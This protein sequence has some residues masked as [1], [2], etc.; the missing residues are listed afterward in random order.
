MS[1][2]PSLISVTCSCDAFMNRDCD[3]AISLFE[4]SLRL[5]GG[6]D[7]FLR[8]VALKTGKLYNSPD[9]IARLRP[10]GTSR[11]GH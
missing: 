10:M 4:K 2:Q 9:L 11:S 8:L 3:E 6:L 7:D 1:H 5:L